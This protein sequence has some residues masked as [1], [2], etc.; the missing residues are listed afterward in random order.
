MRAERLS[1]RVRV[2]APT[3]TRSWAFH[4]TSSLSKARI[5]FSAV[6]VLAGEPRSCVTVVPSSALVT[7]RRVD[8]ASRM[9]R[10][11][12]QHAQGQT[13]DAATV[14]GAVRS[15]RWARTG[16]HAFAA[17]TLGVSRR[18]SIRMASRS[19][20]LRASTSVEFCAT[21]GCDPEEDDEDAPAP[22]QCCRWAGPPPNTRSGK[23][24]TSS[25]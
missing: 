23:E 8:V 7:L 25:S 14:R 6:A 10:T 11:C 15:Q 22:G 19:A 5:C 21:C 4:R 9:S 3:V 17:C 13:R 24:L 12:S 18:P 16:V 1:E 2:R 20:D